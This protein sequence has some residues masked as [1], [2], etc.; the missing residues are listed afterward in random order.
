MTRWTKE[1]QQAIDARNHTVLVSAAAGSG[2]TAVLIERIVALVR[3]GR[4]INRMLIVTFTRAAAGE[5]RQRL[6]Q[7]LTKEAA[8]DPELFGQALDD[9]E[10]ADISTIHSFCQHVLKMN[11]HAIG[12]DPMARICDESQKQQL[13]QQA[14]K[15]A[16]NELLVEPSPN[17]DLMLLVNAFTQSELTE[18][19]SRL[20]TFLMSMPGPFDWLRQ[21]IGVIGEKPFEESNW[22]E[23]LLHK[24]KLSFDGLGHY[25]QMQRE[26]FDEPAALSQ[27]RLTWE[28]DCIL[29]GE[30]M[31][32]LDDSQIFFDKLVTAKFAT[33]AR[34]TKLTAEQEEW[35]KRFVEIRDCIKGVVKEAKDLLLYDRAQNEADLFHVKHELTGLD[36]LIK[37]L[38]EHFMR[39]KNEQNVLDFNDLEQLTL[40]VLSQPAYQKAISEEYDEIFVDECQDVSAVQDAIVQ[41]IH[42]ENNHLFMVGDVKQSI[43][44]FRLADPT[45]FL[46]RMRTFS[47]DE[48]AK[49]RRIFLQKNFRSRANVLDATNRVFRSAMM[50]SVTELDYLPEDELIPGRETVDD[51]KAEI[52]LVKKVKKSGVTDLESETSVVVRRIRE[53][54]QTKFDDNGRERNYQYRD[55]VILL[56][57]TAGVGAKLAELLEE[58]G[59]PVYFDGKDD[60]YSLPEINTVYS[61]LQVIDN[62]SQDIPLLTVLKMIPF[63]LKDSEL[64]DIRMQKTGK[65]V[66]FYEAFKAACEEEKDI[67]ARCRSIAET[68]SSWRF[69]K[70]IMRLSDFIWYVIRESGYYAACGA[71]PE[72]ELRQANLRLLCQRAGEY[73]T[74]FDG[75]L[76][77]FLTMIDQ[78]MHTSDSQSAKILGENENLVRIMT[79]HK[80]KGLEF[81]VVFLMQLTGSMN[82]RNIGGIK[83]HN[84]LGLYLPYINRDMNVKRE[85]VAAEAFKHQR[86][87]DEIAE[88]CRLLYVA[89]TR[90]REVLIMTG[91]FEEEAINWRLQRGEYRVWS[92][93]SMMDWILQAVL[94]DMH[95]PQLPEISQTDGPWLIK[96]EQ[97]VPLTRT[98]SEQDE[99]DTI[100]WATGVAQT[101]IHQAWQTW[102][103]HLDDPREATPIKTSVSS[104]AK[105]QVLR[106]PLP[107]NDEEESTETKRE[108]EEI[109]APLR[110]SELPAKPSFMEEKRVSGAERGTLMHHYL[111]LMPLT[112]LRGL[113]GYDLTKAVTDQKQVFEENGCFEHQELDLID[114]VG[115][116]SFFASP[117]GQRML[118]SDEVR[119]EWGFNL[120]ISREKGTLLQGIIDCAFIENDRWILVDYKTDYITDEAAFVQRHTLQL[121]W[122][123]EALEQITGKP[124]AEMWLYALGKGKPYEVAR[125]PVNTDT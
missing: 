99:Q 6:N 81:P 12:I 89:M 118:A 65:N 121:S 30:L 28:K 26:M 17:E 102:W 8:N 110:M 77:G 16:V 95:L 112:Q 4:R 114:I 63:N 86:R 11:F 51:P 113:S 69:L 35:K 72:G 41:A 94:D 56:S 32:A 115:V 57:K 14:Y 87:M 67:G 104:L 85:L 79:M 52:R 61:L 15:E 18:M 37:K 54:L 96:V 90:A 74:N 105:H 25:L 88:R 60:Y 66:S 59:I 125:V 64:A 78:Q 29:I 122:Y 119:R 48:D 45:L 75:V 62:P 27:L 98:V 5:M 120:R 19:C 33:A 9:L 50:A 42:G 34:T 111:S 107:I 46:S 20:Y 101:P 123:A 22:Y 23:R 116:T 38:H 82:G 3:E 106:D 117:L 84:Q 91:C 68:L 55:M 10:G 39:L 108:A 24:T 80:S 21:H 58:Q 47:D 44:R 73:E 100:L 31:D 71:Y 2:K 97:D 93:D 40:E 70:E 36:V 124:V 103:N 49:E 53:L 109:V 92:A 76:S 7:R 43:Y 1:Q 83:L 13:F